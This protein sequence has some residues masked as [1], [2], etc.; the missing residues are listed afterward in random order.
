MGFA[1]ESWRAYEAME[2]ILARVW[3]NLIGRVGGRFTFRLILQPAVA[4][5]FAIRAGVR[6][7]RQGRAPHGWAIITDPVNRR[8]LMGETWEDV[9]KVFIAAIV[10]DF[11]YQVLEFRWFY[12]E[13]AIIVAALLALLPYLLLRGLTNRIER[14]WRRKD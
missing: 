14:Y 6:D 1:A 4:T 3:V 8:K 5:I 10:V 13:E 2:D 7:A 12:P 9:A 11:A